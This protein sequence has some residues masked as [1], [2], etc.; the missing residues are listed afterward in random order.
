[1][2]WLLALFSQSPLSLALLSVSSLACSSLCLLVLFSL[3]LSDRDRQ[4]Q[5]DRDIQS[6][7]KR[8]ARQR[9]IDGMGECEDMVSRGEYEDIVCDVK[10][11]TFRRAQ[12]EGHAWC[13]FILVVC[14][15]IVVV[16]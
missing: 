12:P 8:Y 2:L 9:Q 14:H 5:R 13:R 16:W 4:R 6:D 11:L 10:S 3:C 15:L 7:T 1:M